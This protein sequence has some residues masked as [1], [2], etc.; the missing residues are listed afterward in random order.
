MTSSIGALGKK[1]DTVVPLI[2]LRPSGQRIEADGK[3]SPERREQGAQ[4]DRVTLSPSVPVPGF[5]TPGNGL[6]PSQAVTP[7]E[8]KALLDADRP[9]QRVSL[10]G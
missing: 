9:R 7:A 6:R 3:S 1:A 2:P 5:S 8:K 4:T 10:Y